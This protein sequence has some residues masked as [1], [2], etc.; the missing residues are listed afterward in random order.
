MLMKMN[1]IERFYAAAFKN[2]SHAID[3]ISIFPIHNISERLKI[4]E[5]NNVS[6]HKH[7]LTCVAD[8]LIHEHRWS[9]V[10]HSQIQ[11]GTS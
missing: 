3:N 10:H 8:T 5:D 7:T 9:I 6:P 11:W 1:A 4:I 2:N